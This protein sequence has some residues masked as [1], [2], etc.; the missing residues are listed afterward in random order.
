MG[1][2]EL[3]ENSIINGEREYVAA[4]DLVIASA[5]EQLFIFD[6]NFSVGDYASTLRFNFIHAFLNKSSSN[7][8]TIILQDPAF[9]ITQCPRLF[10][11]LSTYG[12]QLTVYETNSHA[13]IAKDCFILADNKSYIRRFHIDQPRFKFMLDDEET[14]ASLANRFDELMQE[15]EHTVSA[16]KL[17][18]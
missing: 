15:T 14:T 17:G 13:N 1:E 5:Q 2:S 3:I 6:Q 8:L 4:L 10:A 9:F 7:Q 12:H 18:L 16:S 11:L